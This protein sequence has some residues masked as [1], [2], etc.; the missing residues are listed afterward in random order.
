MLFA[1][2]PHDHCARYLA[3]F[4]A[5]ACALLGDKQGL[6]DTWEHYRSYFD[7]KE[8]NQE[9]FPQ[10]RR[11][12]LTDIPILVRYLEQN[13]TGL[14]RRTVWGLRWR[15]LSNSFN[16]PKPARSSQ[17]LPWWTWWVLG[18]VLI[19]ILRLIMNNGT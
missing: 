12:L 17:P 18:W 16:D 19:Q 15:Y 9:W 13:E 1:I 10:G 6:R 11:H 7:C 2:F 14:Y 4:R 3:H 5:E 8:N